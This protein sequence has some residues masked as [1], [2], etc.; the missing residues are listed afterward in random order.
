[1]QD[2]L[3]SN[4][5][6]HHTGLNEK[7]HTPLKRAALLGEIADSRFGVDKVQ[8]EDK[9]RPPSPPKKQESLQRLIALWLKITR[10]NPKGFP[11][12]K[13]GTVLLSERIMTVIDSTCH[14]HDVCGQEADI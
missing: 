12:V 7:Y 1:M 6:P 9:I 3:S 5:N 10:D 14:V 13:F 11:L 2:H 4:G 8:D